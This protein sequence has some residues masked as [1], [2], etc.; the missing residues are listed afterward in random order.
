MNNITR[1][2]EKL[3]YSKQTNLYVNERSVC[4]VNINFEMHSDLKS[5]DLD[6]GWVHVEI[7]PFRMHFLHT[8]SR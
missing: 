8:M 5:V 7:S 1:E 3:S 6:S 2:K 4:F